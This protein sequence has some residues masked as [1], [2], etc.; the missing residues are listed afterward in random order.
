[1]EETLPHGRFLLLLCGV[2]LALSWIVAIHQRHRLHRSFKDC[3][4]PPP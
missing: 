3:R 1:M 2:G 4:D